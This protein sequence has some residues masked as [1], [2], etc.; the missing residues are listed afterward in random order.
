MMITEVVKESDL[1][2]VEMDPRL[3]ERKPGCT[4]NLGKLLRSA[5]FG[6]PFHRELVASNRRWREIMFESPRHYDL[7]ARLFNAAQWY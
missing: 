6:W 5:R 7:P 1:A 4:V 2:F 3:M